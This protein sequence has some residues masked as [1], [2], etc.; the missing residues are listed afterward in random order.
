MELNG[1]RLTNCSGAVIGDLQPGIKGFTGVE[2]GVVPE[3]KG[4]VAAQQEAHSCDVADSVG[5]ANFDLPT[6]FFGRFNP[7]HA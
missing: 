4:R 7:H 3:S 5:I 6:E 2:V 1:E